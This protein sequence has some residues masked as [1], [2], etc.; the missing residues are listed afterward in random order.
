MTRFKEE[1]GYIILTAL[2]SLLPFVL[3]LFLKNSLPEQVPVHFDFNGDADRYASLR[4][5]QL[6]FLFLPLIHLFAAFITATDPKNRN[7]SPKIYHLLLW[8]VPCLSFVLAY[9]IY[10]KAL[11]RNIDVTTVMIIL[12]AFIYL[13]MGNYLPKTRQNHTVGIKIPWTLSDQDNWDKTH[14]LTGYLWM[15]CG[16]LMLPLVF[17]E[18]KQSFVLLLIIVAIS[19]FVPYLYSFLLYRQKEENR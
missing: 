10:G 19:G 18:R 14:R 8:I 13:I 7:V 1:K 17:L 9:V 5:M 16:A 2:I 3:G 4:E 15:V 11:G 12:M 6:M